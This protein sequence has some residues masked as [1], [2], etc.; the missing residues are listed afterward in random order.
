[1][2][3]GTPTGKGDCTLVARLSIVLVRL[4][5]R[6]LA[7]GCNLWMFMGCI[8]WVSACSSTAE[9]QL[10]SWFWGT[11]SYEDSG[12]YQSWLNF[13]VGQPRQAQRPPPA[14]E[15]RFGWENSILKPV[16]ACSSFG[17]AVLTS[18]CVIHVEC[19]KRHLHQVWTLY[20]N[21]CFCLQPFWTTCF[22]WYLWMNS[23]WKA[24]RS[25]MFQLHMRWQRHSQQPEGPSRQGLFRKEIWSS[26][27]II[28]I[29]NLDPSRVKHD[30]LSTKPR[31]IAHLPGWKYFKF[32]ILLFCC[33][34][35]H[36]WISRIPLWSVVCSICNQHKPLFGALRQNCRIL[37]VTSTRKAFISAKMD[38][39]QLQRYVRHLC[40]ETGCP[41]P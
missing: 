7:I 5:F 4:L 10:L 17:M 32:L 40:G 26:L 16:R 2:C 12:W 25:A 8:G 19:W 30:N 6:D 37:P 11:W 35:R 18:T 24:P 1:M 36:S 33:K 41:K 13:F 21:L 9:M 20:G 39:E 3:E 15:K 28:W 27:S 31:T 38:V 34:I 23:L 22:S 14:Q 29:W